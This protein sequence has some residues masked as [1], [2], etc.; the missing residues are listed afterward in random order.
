MRLFAQKTNGRAF[1]N[2]YR[3]KRQEEIRG[4]GPKGGAARVESR[5]LETES[6]VFSESHLLGGLYVSHCHHLG[7]LSAN[8]STEFKEAN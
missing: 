6:G 2:F 3:V 4:R 8:Q 7:D 1:A 5:W